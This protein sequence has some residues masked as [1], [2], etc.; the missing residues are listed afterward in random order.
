MPTADMA[1]SSPPRDAS[2]GLLK[3]PHEIL[4]VIAS[5]LS[6]PDTRHF[7][8]VNRRLYFFAREYLVR[9]RYTSGLHTLPNEIL[10]QVVQL[11]ETQ[12]DRSRLART[13]QTFYPVV[14][15]FVV[16]Y[17]IRYKESSFLNYTAKQNLEG[18]AQSILHLGGNVE[19][20]KGTVLRLN[21]EKATPLATAARHGH[22]RMVR[23]FLKVGARQLIDGMPY[24]LGVAM[25]LRHENVALIL[26]KE[27]G[28]ND[29]LFTGGDTLLRCSCEA[30]LP[31]LVRF[32]LERAPKRP[33][34]QSVHDRSMALYILLNQTEYKRM[35]LKSDVTEHDYDIV[36]ILLRHGADPDFRVKRYRSQA[37][38]LRQVASRHPDL[39]MRKLLASAR[40]MPYTRAKEPN[41]HSGALLL[42]PQA[43]LW[44][45]LKKSDLDTV[46][47]NDQGRPRPVSND[48]SKDRIL[49]SSDGRAGLGND[50]M[51]LTA[52]SP[53]DMA[54]PLRPSSFP[55]SGSSKAMSRPADQEFRGRTLLHAVRSDR[56]PVQEV[57]PAERPALTETFPQLGRT[58]PS[59]EETGKVC[60]T[61]FSQN[62]KLRASNETKECDGGKETQLPGSKKSKK[63]QW[64]P[65]R[66]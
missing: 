45:F 32:L 26:S 63:K 49:G 38:T 52:K 5:S 59:G 46:I 29:T 7:G 41:L 18:M 35:F 14:M 19:T 65:L 54:A 1:S 24:P 37:E 34:E 62:E 58:V 61:R 55:N 42:N 13:S 15:N 39:Q 31:K 2:L 25:F 20:R 30:K 17:N 60:W 33:N 64:V 47:S 57:K 53:T 9:H 23:L 4:S 28:A 11:L 27:L 56:K 21:G 43:T 22:E 6:I 48:N 51:H 44:D 36:T 50:L 16:R 3:L 40:A 66:I 12:Q 10:L 8:R